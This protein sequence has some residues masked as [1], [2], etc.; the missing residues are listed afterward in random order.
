MPRN[1]EVFGTTFRGEGIVRSDD[2]TKD[3]CYGKNPRYAGGALAG[4]NLSRGVCRVPHGDVLGGLF[5]GHAK[6]GAFTLRSEQGLAGLA[7][8]AAVA[9]DNVRLSQAMQREIEERKLQG[10]N[11]LGHLPTRVCERKNAAL[12]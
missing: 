10:E 7:A 6:T 2:I 9:I 1:T 12:H 3:P 5:L 4:Q 11:S 8:E